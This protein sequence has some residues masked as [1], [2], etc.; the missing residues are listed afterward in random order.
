[1][2]LVTSVERLVE[3]SLYSKVYIASK[4]RKVIGRD[5]F[6]WFAVSLFFASL[7]VLFRT[8]DQGTA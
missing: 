8:L 6:C 7:G 4:Y 5:I 3:N 1:M 2:D